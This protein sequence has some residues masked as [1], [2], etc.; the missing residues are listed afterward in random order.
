MLKMGIVIGY[1]CLICFVFLVAKAITARCHLQKADKFLRKCHK[2]LSVVM[3]ILCILHIIL[4]IPVLRNRSMF[5]NISGIVCVVCLLLLIFLCHV[6]KEPKRRMWWHRALAIALGLGIVCHMVSYYIDF[7][8]YQQKIADIEV[9]NVDL[10][11]IAD[12]IYEGEYDA[13]Y[14]YA[15]VAVEVKD[16][17]IVSVNI[18]EHRNERGKEAESITD[19]VLE[20]QE[21]A[22]DAVSSAT[23]S[24]KVIME[25]IEN[26]LTN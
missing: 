1:L 5:V 26:A 6:I 12:G 18:L 9:S 14:I 11:E 15:K 23:N 7:Q 4:V 19:A 25:A 20:Q 16:G 24:S 21:I 2:P 3:L 13:G 10:S 22:V 8:N 17:T